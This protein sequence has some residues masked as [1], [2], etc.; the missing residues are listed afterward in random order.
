M[1]AAGRH[2][3]E[4]APYRSPHEAYPFLSDPAQDLRCDFELLTDEIASKTGLLRSLVP[5]EEIREELLWVCEA[6]YH[7]NPTLR[8]DLRL[9]PAEMECLERMTQRLK[10]ETGNRSFVLPVGTT[11]ACIAH[12]LRVQAKVLVR[13]MYAAAESGL[14]VPPAAFDFANLLCGYFF[15]LALHLNAAAGVAEIPFESRLDGRA[16]AVEE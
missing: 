2:T 7:F 16:W 6:V 4:G 15:H 11:S 10:Q 5:E 13:L 14:E 3:R 1:T 9:T 12:A 8:T